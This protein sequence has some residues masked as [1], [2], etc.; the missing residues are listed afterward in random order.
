[1]L[2]LYNSFPLKE[3]I[4]LLSALSKIQSYVSVLADSLHRDHPLTSEE[5]QADKI[6]I[7]IMTW[8]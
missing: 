4:I 5:A 2:Y 8:R 3:I 1:M 6:Y 7:K